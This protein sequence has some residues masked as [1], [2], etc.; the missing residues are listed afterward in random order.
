MEKKFARIKEGALVG[1]DFGFYQ[2]PNIPCPHR[3]YTVEMLNNPI[4][5][6]EYYP[7]ECYTNRVFVIEQYVLKS[8]IHLRC[9]GFG[10]LNSTAEEYGNGAVSC[11]DKD[12]IFVEESEY[13]SSENEIDNY[14]NS[15]KKLKEENVQYNLI[16]ILEK[17]YNISIKYSNE[18]KK[19]EAYPVNDIILHGPFDDEDIKIVEIFRQ[20]AWIKSKSIK[21]LNNISKEAHIWEMALNLAQEHA[22]KWN[23]ESKELKYIKEQFN[24]INIETNWN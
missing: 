18:C 4:Q 11:Y 15:L 6:D 19:N 23:R 3:E 24:A 12:L 9:K 2:W 14:V 8:R 5:H 17:Q 16:K 21:Y 22:F 7:L 20:L 1:Q 13:I 10:I